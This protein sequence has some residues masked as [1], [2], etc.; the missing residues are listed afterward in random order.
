[1]DGRK[2]N[3]FLC[4]E[5]GSLPTS[6]PIDSMK[7]GQIN[8]LNRLGVIISTA[9]PTISNPMVD[10]CNYAKKVLDGVIEDETYFALLYEPN[11]DIKKDW[12]E[13]DNVIFQSNPLALEIDDNLD[14]LYKQRTDAINKP[15][16]EVNFLTKH[17]NIFVNAKN[18]ESLVDFEIWKKCEVDKVDFKGKK[19]TLGIDGSISVDLTGICMSYREGNNYYFKSLGMLPRETIR[20]RRE[21]YDYYH[22]ERYKECLI[23]DGLVIDQ[24]ALKEYILSIENEY[25]CIIEEI[26]FDQYNLV[27]LM[28]EL[29]ELYDCVSIRQTYSQLSAPT[30]EF[31][32][33][34]AEGRVFYEKSKLLDIHM[35]DTLISRGKSGDIMITKE[36]RK[37]NKTHI[38]LVSAMMFCMVRLVTKIPPIDLNKKILADDFIM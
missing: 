8:M 26:V 19:V 16:S 27:L 37:D 7:S 20:D 31:Q 5:A 6:Y 24:K 3:F 32:I 35:S 22:G 15:S 29:S 13:N 25:G 12:R 36:T 28:N 18:G 34:V 17:L 21:K 14:Y 33:A 9:Y 30:K 38:D 10:E 4:D 1:M 23:C 11:E 2:P